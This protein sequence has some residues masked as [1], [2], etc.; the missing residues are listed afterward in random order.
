MG[1]ILVSLKEA[2]AAYRNEIL[3][4]LLSVESK[5]KGIL[6]PQ[7]LVGVT[8]ANKLTGHAFKQ[9]LN[10]TQEAVVLPPW[11]LLAVRPKPGIWLYV[12]LNV[13]TLSADE[14]TVPEY[15]RYKE[16]IVVDGE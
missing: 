14:V 1:E 13:D 12:K 10:A 8:E 9:L 16:Q 5:G 4:F 2:I 3:L 6:K 7:Q 11:I 15:L